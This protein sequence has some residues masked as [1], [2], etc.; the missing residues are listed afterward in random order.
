MISRPHRGLVPFA[1]CYSEM[2]LTYLTIV[3]GPAVKQTWKTFK[4]NHAKLATDNGLMASSIKFD[5]YVLAGVY[6]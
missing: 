5:N 1:E 6:I 4:E 3:F 2:T